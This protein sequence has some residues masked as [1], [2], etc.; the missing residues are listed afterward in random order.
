VGEVL[1]HGV[2]DCGVESG[3]A[4][5]ALAAHS[6]GAGESPTEAGV[7]DARRR[8]G[9]FGDPFIAEA[10][11]DLQEAW[12]R[13]ADRL[14]EDEQ[15]VATVHAALRRRRPQSARRGRPGTPAEVVLRLLVLKHVRNWSFAVLEREVRTN[16][17]YRTFTR[18]GGGKVPD[19]KTMGKWGPAVG[20][21]VIAQLHQRLIEIARAAHVVEGRKMRVDTT[22]VETNVHYPTDS[23]LLGDGVRVLTRTMRRVTAIAGAVGTR[24]RDR[25]RSV[26]RRLMEIGRIARTKGAQRQE[27]LT[28]SYQQLFAAT[29]RVVGQA[30]RFAAE[31]RTGVKQSADF[32]QQAMLE[33][34]RH[35]LETF[36]PRVQQVLRQARARILRGDTHAEGKLLSLFEPSTEVIRKGKAGKPNEFGKLVKIQEA[37]QQ[38]IT[39]YE[40]YDQRPSDSDL[41]LPAIDAH[42]QVCGR[43]P[44][45]VTADAAF[46]SG[47]NE[48][49][50]H[51]KGVTRV[52]IPNRSTKSAARKREQKKRWF[53]NGQKWRTGCEGRISVVKRR[54]GLT[55]SRYKDDPGM[56]RWVGLG[57]IAD[58]LI[59]ISHA[60]TKTRRA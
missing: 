4:A 23:S 14:L 48:D 12:M 33:G 57:V 45:L 25:S 19:A 40:V 9:H 56:K 10:V 52:C 21:A 37:E 17:V 41:L 30:K 22:V 26:K 29:S 6:R 11:G 32:M 51:A 24:L 5:S 34:L 60:L 16:L 7:T 2:R 59:N 36:V 46:Y 42:T 13:Q 18:V 50:A 27:R 47:A 44:R 39:H 49:A 55:R 3:G 15:L 54:H 58:N 38:I 28:R 35:D 8:Q 53:K 31:I 20:P 43:V 1:G